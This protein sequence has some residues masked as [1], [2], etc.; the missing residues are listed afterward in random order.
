MTW[1]LRAPSRVG[2]VTVLAM[3]VA[4]VGCNSAAAPGSLGSRSDAIAYFTSKGFSGSEASPATGASAAA[5]GASAA[6]LWVGKGPDSALG[7]VSGSGNSVDWVS[8]SVDAQGSGGDLLDAFLK[9]FAPGSGSFYGNVL[10]DTSNGSSQDQSRTIGGRRVRIQT[11]GTGDSY[12]IA[13]TVTAA[14]AP[15]SAQ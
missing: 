1:A 9:H 12:L 10:E 3:L 6:P 2:L 15:G 11:I 13:M 14:A 8:I 5:A 7:E 4:V